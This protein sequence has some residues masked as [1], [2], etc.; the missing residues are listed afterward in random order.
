MLFLLISIF[1]SF[2]DDSATADVFDLEG[3]N[4]IYT[5]KVSRKYNQEQ[6]HYESE[7]KDAVTG[8]VVATE[9]ADIDRGRIVKYEVQRVP[10]KE[11][12]LIEVK[13]G[14]ISFLYTENGQKSESKEAF[15]EP[16]LISATLVTVLE[17]QMESL[18]A[19]KD[20]DFRYA[21]WFRRETVGFRFSLEKEENGQVV[22]KMNPTNFLYKSLV[23]PIFF[24]F[25]KSNK[26][27]LSIRGRTL[28]KVKEGSA[29]KDF[30]ALTLYK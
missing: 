6:M 21:V 23:K 11:T 18:L 22:I 24:T 10:T 19:K 13:E 8:D 2:A 26:K 16:T 20:F 5:Y 28:P 15:R 12:G 25:Q 27:L 7:Y 14:K 29:W 17:Q 3:K 1:W 9:K 4:K 30:D